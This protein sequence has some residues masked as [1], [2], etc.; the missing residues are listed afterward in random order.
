MFKKTK[1]VLSGLKGS[2]I[3][4]IVESLFLIVLVVLAILAII[5]PGILLKASMVLIVFGL[6]QISTDTIPLVHK[7][8]VVI[9]GRRL[10]RPILK[11][12]LW[13]GIIP[14]LIKIEKIDVSV[15]VETV[16]IQNVFAPEDRAELTVNVEMPYKVI[17]PYRF[18]EIKDDALKRLRAILEETV[19][20]FASDRGC[21]PRNFEEAVEAGPKFTKAIVGAIY[22]DPIPKDEEGNH[23]KKGQMSEEERK[24]NFRSEEMA[25]KLKNGEGELEV[26][27]TGLAILGLNVVSVEPSGSLARNL[28]NIANERQQLESE[29]I[30]G[31]AMMRVIDRM[32]SKFGYSEDAIDT[33]EKK[34]KALKE[35]GLED[36]KGALHEYVSY[37]QISKGE[38][39]RV[40]GL[41]GLLPILA[42][43]IGGNN[44]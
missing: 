26:P 34:L 17:D 28:E 23:K 35:M 14:K 7:G 43:I 11:E 5:L 42:K 40:E 32:L 22:G 31:E 37:G 20:W 30:Q 21:Y 16:K 12:G 19:R 4:I 2:T 6:I 3:F 36:V 27:G 39:F 41:E 24:R 33:P 25:D 44:G 29:P 9:L 1:E 18:Y 15:K 13:P 8:I 10:R 38:I